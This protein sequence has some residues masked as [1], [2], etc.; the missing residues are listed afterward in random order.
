MGI[1]ALVLLAVVVVVGIWVLSMALDV[2]GLVVKLVVWV[3]IA[4]VVF[5]AIAAARRRMRR[6]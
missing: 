4:I 5:V 6:G 3:V 2:I 1:R